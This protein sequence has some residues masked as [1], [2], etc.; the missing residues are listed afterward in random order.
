MLERF[1]GIARHRVEPPCELAR[2][3]VICAEVAAHIE[4]GT[5]RADDH[6]VFEDAHGAGDGDVGRRVGGLYGPHLF[7]GIRIQRDQPAVDQ[8]GE[9]LAIREG[10]AAIDRAAAHAGSICTC[11]AVPD[12]SATCLR[13]CAHRMPR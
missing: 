5:C 3:C 8:A 1:P 9:D 2:F 4:L 11:E 12:P 13:R 7:A 10:H 6:F